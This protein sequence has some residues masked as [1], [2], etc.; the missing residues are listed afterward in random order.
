M[1]YKNSSAEPQFRDIVNGR[2]LAGNAIYGTVVEIS[3]PFLKGREMVD[4]K[5][6]TVLTENGKVYAR[7]S[8]CEPV[9][10]PPDP[11]AAIRADV[12]SLKAGQAALQQV[13]AELAGRVQAL[14][15]VEEPVPQAP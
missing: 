6:I 1:N 9:A 15:P 5:S 2:D 3:Q 11:L 13:Q 10:P 4:K 7:A 14:K 8:E 12:E